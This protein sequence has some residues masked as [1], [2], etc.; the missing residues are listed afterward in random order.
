ML[1]NIL[2]IILIYFQFK[3]TFL[4][5][6]IYILVRQLRSFSEVSRG[7][8]CSASSVNI[9]KENPHC[10]SYMQTKFCSHLLLFWCIYYSILCWQV[11]PRAILWSKTVSCN[12][13]WRF[14]IHTFEQ[15]MQFWIFHFCC[16][17]FLNGYWNSKKK[18]LTI[19]QVCV[20]HMTMEI[21]ANA[22]W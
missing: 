22:T 3:P 18:I 17:F 21:V 12:D 8:F 5:I 13:A 20:I 10:L 9:F 14:S 7:P 11:L 1:R 19:I 2:L 15:S 16:Y 6:I 4:A